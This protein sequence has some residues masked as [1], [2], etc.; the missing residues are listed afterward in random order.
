[1]SIPATI[2]T[3]LA[4]SY[5]SDLGYILGVQVTVLPFVLALWFH[6]RSLTGWAYPSVMLIW[7]QIAIRDGLNVNNPLSNPL[8]SPLDLQQAQYLYFVVFPTTIVACALLG[9]AVAWLLGLPFLIPT[10]SVWPDSPGL[11]FNNP[12]I[13]T[14]GYSNSR[15][16]ARQDA[17]VPDDCGLTAFGF[18]QIPKQYF[19]FL[20][21][22]VLFVFTVALPFI[23]FEWL[24]T[25]TK[26]GAF[27]CCLL[28]P[29]VGYFVSGLFWRY[30]TSLYVFG[31]NEKNMKDRDDQMTLNRKNDD[32]TMSEPD[33]TDTSI[34]TM[35]YANTNYNIWKTVII[36][37]GL[38]VLTFL[39]VG[40]VATFTDPVDVDVVWILGICLILAIAFIVAMVVIIYHSVTKY[41]ANCAATAN[42]SVNNNNGDNEFLDTN[43]NLL[44]KKSLV[45]ARFLNSN[46]G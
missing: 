13:N 35:V 42:T 26:L 28:I 43:A 31:P 1:M 19:H 14:E 3:V 30:V 34:R 4:D 15:I 18:T 25:T 27:L 20:V 5:L 44:N 38:H 41:R 10:E 32:R 24:Y 37:G 11:S 22:L 46:R 9:T 29:V 40:G 45:T 16:L 8:Y 33:L 39:L 36:I 6:N 17:A 2:T 12:S 7:W 23:L 21:T